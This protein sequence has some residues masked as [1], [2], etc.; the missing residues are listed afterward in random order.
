M[1]NEDRFYVVTIVIVAIMLIIF[2]V[3]YHGEVINK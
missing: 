1:D 3:S 2:T